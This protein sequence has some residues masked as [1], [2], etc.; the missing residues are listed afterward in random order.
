MKAQNESSNESSSETFTGSFNGSAQCTACNYLTNMQTSQKIVRFCDIDRRMVTG[1][2]LIG[3]GLTDLETL[4]AV[5]NMPKPMT[6]NTYSN[7]AKALRAAAVDIAKQS[8]CQAA[9]ELRSE[10][11]QKDALD[12]E[13]SC[14]GSWHRRSHLCMVLLQ[15]YLQKL[16]KCLTIP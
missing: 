5:L 1:M 14:D 15:Y 9:K 8:R 13:V 6:P 3:R 2:H 4:C 7:H 10:H 11:V 16:V 12:I